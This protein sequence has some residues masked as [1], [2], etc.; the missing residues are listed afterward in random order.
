MARRLPGHFF[1]WKMQAGHSDAA[2]PRTALTPSACGHCKPPPLG[3]CNSHPEASWRSG[4][5]ADCKSVY[6]GSIPGEASTHTSCVLTRCPVAKVGWK[7]ISAGAWRCCPCIF[8][9]HHF[10]CLDGVSGCKSRLETEF[11]PVLGAALHDSNEL[12]RLA[13]L[14]V[15]LAAITGCQHGFPFFTGISAAG[16]DPGAGGRTSAHSQR[17]TATA[18]QWPVSRRDARP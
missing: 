4:D 15:R 9:S 18:P 17:R 8:V 14:T 11:L 5:A 13:C 12:S 16:T 3:L 2:L 1:T 10:V 7:P 6:P